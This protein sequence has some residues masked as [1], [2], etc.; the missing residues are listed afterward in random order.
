M[1]FRQLSIQNS[2]RSSIPSRALRY[3]ST[4]AR[5]KAAA[6]L[7]IR[8]ERFGAQELGGIRE[9]VRRSLI[10]G[11]SEKEGRAETLDGIPSSRQEKTTIASVIGLH[12]SPTGP[13]PALR[14]CAHGCR[15][16]QCRC[17]G[18]QVLSPVTPRRIR[19]AKTARSPPNT[20]DVL[21]SGTL[22]DT[23]VTVGASMVMNTP[24][25]TGCEESVA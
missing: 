3:I 21:G 20:T 10:I 13:E 16:V 17:S 5:K 24:L 14:S 23:R 22:V 2:S 11:V 25:F 19:A 6:G 7:Q 15:S 18:L 9:Y 8:V 1:T 4:T 12:I